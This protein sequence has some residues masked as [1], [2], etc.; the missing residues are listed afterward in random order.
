MKA[1]SKHNKLMISAL[2]FLI[3]LLST[4]H[5]SAQNESELAGDEAFELGW[6]KTALAHYKTAIMMSSQ[7]ADLLHKIAESA[8]LSNDYPQAI[9]Y[10]LKLRSSTGA[11]NYPDT[12]FKLA[13]MYKCNGMPDSALAYFRTYVRLFPKNTQLEQR[14]KEEIKACTLIIS[15]SIDKLHRTYKVF[16]EGKSLNTENSESGAVLVGDSIVLFSRIDE[17]FTPSSENSLFEN[18]ILQQIYQ[19]RKG[20]NGRYS[21][22]KLNNWGL[23]SKKRHSGNVAYDAVNQCI[24]FTYGEASSF[25]E[26]LCNIYVS[27]LRNGKWTSPK[28]L[29]KN[30]NVPNYTST[31]PAV[32]HKDGVTILLYASNRPGGSGGMDIWYSIVDGDDISPS[33]NLG[34]PVNTPGNEITPFYC[35]ATGELYFSSDYHHGFGGYDIFRSSGFRDQWSLPDNLGSAINSSANDIYFTVNVGDSLSGFLT[36]NR[37]GSYFI[38]DNTCCNDIYSW[39]RKADTLV[40]AEEPKHDTIQHEI[41]YEAQNEARA[42]LPITLFF[43]NDEPDPRSQKV[44]TNKTYSDVYISY[45]SM[46]QDYIKSQDIRENPQ[47]KFGTIKQ[48][49]LFFDS[50]LPQSYS[51]LD[52]LM[53]LIIRDMREGR[54]VRLLV[55]GYASPL[56]TEKYNFALSKRRISSFLNE[57]LEYDNGVISKYMRNSSMGGSLQI[58]ELALGSSTA[59]KTVSSDASNQTKSVYSPEA[60]A[61]RRIE[62]M[63]YQYAEDNNNSSLQLPAGTVFLGSFDRDTSV[64]VTVSFPITGGKKFTL[65]F[66]NVASPNVRIIPYSETTANG[67]L[68]FELKINTFNI[69]SS[70][71]MFIPLTIRVNNESSTQT[72]F[73]EYRVKQ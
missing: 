69:N 25:S 4:T 56:A 22:S 37:K 70:S 44:T 19:V 5:V 20:K 29:G 55:K 31:Q 33:V 27:H 3:M 58:E 67:K 23:N 15:D 16:H 8:R 62:I 6:Y 51:D 9:K 38:A 32:A 43:H 64:T 14:A 1:I 2:L 46:R 36:S 47:D 35:D 59:P 11:A 53:R 12:D 60:I 54:H 30:I 26:I 28:K 61:E 66:L 45:I 57:L 13:S 24:Y 63:D 10:Y 48:L 17:I 68:N 42:L 7:N 21:A 34:H 49:E 39:R 40:I 71:P 72:I 18:F 65:N 73:L 52:S 50:T 41:V